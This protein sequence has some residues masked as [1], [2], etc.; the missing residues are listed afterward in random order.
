MFQQVH[1]N[2]LIVGEK[3]KMYNENYLH[4]SEWFYTGTF[5]KHV[6]LEVQVF[7]K[8]VFH[9]NGTNRMDSPI[10][11]EYRIFEYHIYYRFVS[12]KEQIQ[13]AMEQRALDKI[14]KRLINDDFTW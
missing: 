13:Q 1:A 10:I 8:V 11:P 2:N 4:I 5:Y 3:Y 9:A 6:A 7:H 12:K 14:L